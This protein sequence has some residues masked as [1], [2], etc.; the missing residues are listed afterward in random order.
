MLFRILL[1]I[2]KKVPCRKG[3]NRSQDMLSLD[4]W[5]IQNQDCSFG[6]PGKQGDPID[7][8]ETQ[9]TVHPQYVVSN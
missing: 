9:A 2:M 7:L 6:Q 3:Q 5:I 4:D 8:D 1:A